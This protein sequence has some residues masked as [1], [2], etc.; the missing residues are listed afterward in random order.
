M[1]Y[2]WLVLCYNSF[3]VQHKA[4]F[5][6]GLK[7]SAQDKYIKCNENAGPFLGM[8]G[9]SRGNL[10]GEY[11]EHSSIVIASTLKQKTK[12]EFYFLPFILKVIQGGLL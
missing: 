2:P 7:K 1:Q 4:E 10:F 12:R 8:K 11:Q 6:C 9:N 3:I 5:V